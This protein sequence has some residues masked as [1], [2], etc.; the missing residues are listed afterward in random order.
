M[1][2][3]DDDPANPIPRYLF[4]V[5]QRMPVNEEISANFHGATHTVAA[6][7]SGA[8]A[9][10]QVLAILTDLLA[11]ESSAKTLPPPNVIA[12]AP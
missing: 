1:D 6:D 9:S 12:I 7:P 5:E 11:L 10:S 4:R 8:N 2:V 3:K